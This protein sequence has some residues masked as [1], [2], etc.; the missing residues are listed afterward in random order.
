MRGILWV[1]LRLPG[2]SGEKIIYLDDATVG[3]FEELSR[4]LGYTFTE[5]ENAEGAAKR[6][7][8]RKAHL[9]LLMADEMIADAGEPIAGAEP[10]SDGVATVRSLPRVFVEDIVRSAERGPCRGLQT[11]LVL[12][13]RSDR[14]KAPRSAEISHARRSQF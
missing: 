1:C 11:L 4:E 14:V 12:R 10:A 9:L 7:W 6:R 3:K 8:L 5:L 2:D 13:P